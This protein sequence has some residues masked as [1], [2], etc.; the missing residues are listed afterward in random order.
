MATLYSFKNIQSIHTSEQLIDI[1]LSKTQRKTPTEVHPKYSVQRIRAFYMRKVKFCADA[2]KEKLTAIVEQFPKVEDIHPFFADILNVLYDRDHY[3]IA[4]GQVNVIRNVVEKIANDYVK[5][6]KF[7]ESLFRCKQLKIAA[8]GRMCTAVKKINPSLQYLEEVRKHLGRLPNIDPFVPT[9][10]LFGCPNVGK[11]SYI[12]QITRANVEVSAIPFSTQ[13]LFV[14]HTEHKN[15]KIQYIDSPGVLDRALDQRNTIEMQSLTAL[16][17]L[18][19]LILFIVDISES[20]G[21]SLQDQLTL[22]ENLKPLFKDKPV[23]LGLN[24]TDLCS[25]DSLDSSNKMLIEN[26]QKQNPTVDLV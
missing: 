15:V 1:V 16:A 23:V 12:N 2:F 4:L 20:C 7:S 22:F 3:K 26:F 9:V 5:F 10:L 19:S 13:N 21:S 17:H 25:W 14:G 24:K 11:S 8:F 18:K 6:M